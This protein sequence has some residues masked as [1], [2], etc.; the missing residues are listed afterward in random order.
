MDNPLLNK[1]KKLHV[2]EIAPDDVDS[3]Q[4]AEAITQLFDIKAAKSHINGELKKLNKAQQYAERYISE[5][6]EAA[7]IEK[8][9]IEN[10]GTASRKVEAYPSIQKGHSWN[11][12]FNW[13]AENARFDMVYKRLNAA[14]CR[15]MLEQG[16]T[17]E[18]LDFFMKDKILT[19]SK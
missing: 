9:T 14:P 12:A 19:R 15:E 16:E 13:I 11:D 4:L 8:T 10:V 7:G 18:W 5:L 17:P 2:P 3:K 6:M 1:A